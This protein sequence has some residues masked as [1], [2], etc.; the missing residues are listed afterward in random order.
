MPD[1]FDLDAERNLACPYFAIDAWRWCFYWRVAR[2]LRTARV[3]RF[4]GV[5]SIDNDRTLNGY[6]DFSGLL[7]NAHD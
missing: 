3:R 7:D 1:P 4:A 2:V 5:E 6:D